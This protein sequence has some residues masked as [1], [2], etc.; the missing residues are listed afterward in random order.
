MDKIKKEF[1]KEFPYS[2]M[3]TESE[4]DYRFF[5]AGHKSRDKEVQRLDIKAD[6]LGYDIEILETKLERYEY[7]YK[8]KQAENKKLEDL[9]DNML[10]LITKHGIQQ[11][12]KIIEAIKDGE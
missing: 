4:Q 3:F 8:L 6:T 9:T 11:S 5:E 12:E 10:L 1:E 2:K 7:K